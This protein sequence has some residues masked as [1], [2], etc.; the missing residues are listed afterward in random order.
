MAKSRTRKKIKKKHKIQ[1]MQQESR[2]VEEEKVD[3]KR[4]KLEKS[5]KACS[6]EK[7]KRTAKQPSQERQGSVEQRKT[8]KV[9]PRPTCL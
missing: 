8:K 1:A 7:R 9:D 3:K 2:R 5:K 6:R 4:S